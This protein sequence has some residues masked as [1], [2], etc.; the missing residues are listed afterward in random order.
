MTEVPDFS[1]HERDDRQIPG[2]SPED[3]AFLAG[4]D[5]QADEL[6]STY[7]NPTAEDLELCKQAYID[8]INQRTDAITAYMQDRQNP[9]LMDYLRAYETQLFAQFCEYVDVLLHA[10][11]DQYGPNIV[12]ELASALSLADSSQMQIN[13]Q[14]GEFYQF[15]VEKLRQSILNVIM[16]AKSAESTHTAIQE[17]YASHIRNVV[18]KFIDDNL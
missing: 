17:L 15:D 2:I 8:A 12:T 9:A 13:M 11:I 5:T 3:M 7:E 14:S 4:L 6:F 1:D 16:A 18:M 10:P